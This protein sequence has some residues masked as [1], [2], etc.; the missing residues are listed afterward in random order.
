LQAVHQEVFAR[1]A[2]A[3]VLG[4]NDS[5]ISIERTPPRTDPPADPN[6]RD[7]TLATPTHRSQEGQIAIS[8]ANVKLANSGFYPSLDFTASVQNSQQMLYTNA[9]NQWSVGLTL[10]IPLF[11]GLSTYYSTKSAHALE[12]AARDTEVYSDFTT[13]ETLRQALF[14]FQEA[15]QLLRVN[16]LSLNALSIQERIATKQYNNGLMTFE[17]WDIIEGNLVT[18]EKTMLTGDENRD[19]YESSWRLSQGLGDF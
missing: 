17:N 10:T 11:S 14:N 6:L 2:L 4:Q 15:V 5:D 18:S 8:K 9:D 7:L 1:E 13:Y 16:Q 12:N 19:L 3:H